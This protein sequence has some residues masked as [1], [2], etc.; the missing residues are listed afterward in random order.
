MRDQFEVVIVGA[1]HGGAQVAIALRQQGFTGTLAI[2][3]E[4]PELPYE[5]PPLSKDY[6]SGDKISSGC[7]SVRRPFGPNAT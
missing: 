4:E 7:S 5:R 6:L 1:S 3:G 2:V